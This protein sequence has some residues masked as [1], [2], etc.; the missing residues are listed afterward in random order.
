MGH[1]LIC[2]NQNNSNLWCSSVKSHILYTA[3]IKIVLYHLQI[4]THL[5]RIVKTRSAELPEVIP[6]IWFISVGSLNINIG[7]K[8]VWALWD[9]KLQEKKKVS[10][11]T[12][13]VEKSKERRCN[14][15]ARKMSLPSI[16][17]TARFRKDMLS[18]WF[19]KWILLEFF[20]GKHF[21]GMLSSYLTY[22]APLCILLGSTYS[23][24]LEELSVCWKE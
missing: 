14:E 24:R 5:A 15:K 2:W 20:D 17:F 16:I 6:L 19:P 21:Q 3:W 9:T 8:S 10:K 1:L 11:D 7:C 18:F 12:L 4:H 23:D 22:Q 13:W